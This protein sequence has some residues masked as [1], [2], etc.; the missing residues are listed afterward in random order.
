MRINVALYG[1]LKSRPVTFNWKEA[2]LNSNPTVKKRKNVHF[3]AASLQHVNLESKSIETD[4]CSIE[5][6]D[7]VFS[8]SHHQLF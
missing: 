7:L 5:Y 1:V 3:R 4:I 2:F 6:D 8:L